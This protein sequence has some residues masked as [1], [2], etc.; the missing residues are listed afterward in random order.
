MNPD[1][2]TEPLDAD[3]VQRI[4]K[5]AMRILSDIGIEIPEPRCRG[6]PEAGRVAL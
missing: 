4:H 3:G 6:D 1:R 5:G 2:P